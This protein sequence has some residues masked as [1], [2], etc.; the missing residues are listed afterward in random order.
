MSTNV[1]IYCKRSNN[2]LSK[3]E[4]ELGFIWCRKHKEHFSPNDSCE[5]FIDKEK[6]NED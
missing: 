1:C 2:K 3:F 6:K 5:Y 4:N